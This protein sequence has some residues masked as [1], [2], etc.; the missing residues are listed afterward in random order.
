MEGQEFLGAA[1]CAGRGLRMME[2]GCLPV[3]KGMPGVFLDVDFR[4][5]AVSYG[6]LYPRHLITQDV[7]VITAKVELD[8]SA[9]LRQH[10]RVSGHL[11]TVEGAHGLDLVPRR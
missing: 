3:V 8:R 7:R 1:P 9:D 5:L 6:F 2:H 10:I 4:V 11:R